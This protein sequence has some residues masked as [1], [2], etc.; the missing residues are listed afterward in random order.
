MKKP[1]QLALKSK[2]CDKDGKG[3]CQFCSFQPGARSC[4][5]D[6]L[7]LFPFVFSHLKQLAK[8]K[9]TQPNIVDVTLAEPPVSCCLPW[10]LEQILLFWPHFAWK[11]GSRENCRL[12]LKPTLHIQVCLCVSPERKWATLVFKVITN[13]IY[14]TGHSVET[15]FTSF[16]NVL[17]CV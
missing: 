16:A 3:G 2:R 15:H 1:L 13:P 12:R 6:S 14:L 7:C 11:P 10:H 8:D 9:N 17:R 4:P 5:D